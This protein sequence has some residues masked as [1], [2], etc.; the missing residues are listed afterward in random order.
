MVIMF[1]Y[2]LRG[3][4]LFW[5]ALVLGT[6]TMLS[7]PT[8]GG[9]YLIDIP[10]GAAVALIAILVVRRWLPAPPGLRISTGVPAPGPVA[11]NQPP[12]EAIVSKNHS[13]I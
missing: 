13:Q 6:I 3:T 9:H 4:R 10:G 8:I 12:A 1:C 5:P 2:A 7:L 11:A